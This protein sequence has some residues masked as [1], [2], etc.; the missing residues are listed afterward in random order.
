[1]VRGPVVHQPPV[2]LLG[3]G[4]SGVRPVVSGALGKH[5]PEHALAPSLAVSLARLNDELPPT[6]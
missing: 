2:P 1:M 5:I 4:L 3:I 6:A